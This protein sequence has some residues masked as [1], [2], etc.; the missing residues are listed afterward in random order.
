[1]GKYRILPIIAMMKSAAINS[2]DVAIDYRG[3]RQN[4]QYK[5]IGMSIGN[6]LK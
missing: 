6:R 4:N 1:M 2:Y 3:R 5:S